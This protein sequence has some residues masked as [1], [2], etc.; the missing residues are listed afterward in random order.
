MPR[1][2]Y[3]VSIRNAYGPYQMSWPWAYAEQITRADCLMY[4]S[5]ETVAKADAEP[6]EWQIVMVTE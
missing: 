1:D 3:P 6:G 5:E 4:V 2:P